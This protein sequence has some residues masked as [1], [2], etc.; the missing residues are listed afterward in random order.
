[1]RRHCVKFYPFGI[2]KKHLEDFSSQAEGTRVNADIEYLHRMRVAG[3]RLRTALSTF[4][5][6][7]PE[8]YV[9]AVKTDVRAVSRMLGKARDC[10]MQVVF[11]RRIIKERVL[12]EHNAALE[13]L[14]ELLKR[15]RR[16]IQARV[17]K[18][19]DIFKNR[20]SF[21]GMYQALDA[22]I[23]AQ[24]PSTCVLCRVA[25]KK[26]EKRL[27]DYLSFKKYIRQPEK[28]QE[29][30]RMRIA[31]KHLRYTL[32]NLEPLYEKKIN[33]FIEAAHSIQTILGRLHD[34][35]VWIAQ[36][37][38]LAAK[39]KNDRAYQDALTALRKYCITLRKKSHREFVSVWEEQKKENLWPRLRAYI[40]HAQR[41]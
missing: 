29:L 24:L 19:L 31:A 37:P 13:K 35:D 34:L 11:V 26:A 17:I 30:H 8:D 10:D 28:V 16:T 1:M 23:D 27:R 40:K 21:E 9:R 3:R 7:L 5:K 14:L 4:K 25:I 22:S 15:Q 38:L 33:I 18:K 41:S 32:E 12:F 39:K 6:L 36:L 20:N 2:I